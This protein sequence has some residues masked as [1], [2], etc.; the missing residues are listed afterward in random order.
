MQMRSSA[1]FRSLLITLWFRL[2]TLAV[3]SSVFYEALSLVRGKAQGWSFY[4]PGIE[5]AY[6]VLA[7]LIAASVI[8]LLLGTLA[9]AA[10]APVLWF[11]KSWRVQF[12]D[13]VTKVAVASVVFFISRYVLITLIQWSVGRSSN[14]STWS[15]ESSSHMLVEISLMA[16]YVAFAW[17]MCIPRARKEILHSLDPALTK[18]MTRRTALVTVAGAAGFVAT[19]HAFGKHL[20]TVK[21]AVTPLH[22]KG[23]FLV[24][25]FDALSA[26]DMSLYGCSRPTTPSMDAFAGKATVFMKFFSTS[27]F[28]TPAIATILTGLYPSESRVYHLQG[29]ALPEFGARNLFN[30][31]RGAGYST[32]AFISNPYAYYFVKGF[33][34]DLDVFPEPVFQQGALEHLW[35]AL[36]P[37]HRDPR[38]GC[39]IEEYLDLA[40]LWNS[41][42]QTPADLPMRYRPEMSF[43]QARRILDKLRDGFFLWV[44]V[45]A[46]HG[47]YLPAPVDL[48]RFLP[49]TGALPDETKFWDNWKRRYEPHHQRFVDQWRLRYDEFIVTVDRA[50]G[51]FLSELD[52]TGRLNDT[53]VIVMADHGESFQGSVFQHNSAYLT[54]PV[55]HVPL[56]IRT[57]GQ[58]RGRSVAVAADQTSIAPTILEL[59]GQVKPDFM[60][61]RSLVPWLDASGPVNEEGL[62][63]TQYLAESNIFKPLHRGTFGVIDGDYEYIAYLDTQKGELR[64]LNEAHI[65]NLDRSAENPARASALRAALH[66]RFPDAVRLDPPV[67]GAMGR[68]G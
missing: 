60:R 14:G 26:E 50:F 38:F 23:N 31:L 37:L 59:A 28:T 66:S 30:L 61:G 63:F 29:R 1:T 17:A 56:I 64:P 45:M 55:I 18:P 44:H 32:G 53:S 9:A 2:V 27:T 12:A 35:M 4:L 11:F 6:E 33:E 42:T 47:P 65:W 48:G 58:K 20:S 41:L 5:V 46:P 49:N 36:P 39:P 40:H 54:R 43:L 3:V 62:A 34:N 57:P 7:R 19:E 16:F 10:I 21:A 67:H 8:G 24:I 25:S 13:L 22:P 51:D 68:A 52:N 15:A